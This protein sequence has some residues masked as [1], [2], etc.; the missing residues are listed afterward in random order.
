MS[1][2]L[3][4]LGAFVALAFQSMPVQGQAGA[5]GASLAE[6]ASLA[7]LESLL[8]A[9]HP[10]LEASRARARAEGFKARERESRPP[11][12]LVYQQWAVPLQRP[13]DLTQANMLMLGARLPVPSR[14][15]RKA[16]AH[17]A[18]LGAEAAAEEE[19]VTQN[20]L[21]WE[22]RQSFAEY[23]RT[24]HELALHHEHEGLVSG[25]VELTKVAYAANQV[26]AG[27][28]HEARVMLSRLHSEITML[29]AEHARARLRLN[30]LTGR[31]PDA[32]LGAPQAAE[33]RA[34]SPG[35]S[36]V[37][38]ELS[39]AEKQVKSQSAELEARKLAATRPSFMVGVDYMMMPSDRQYYGYGA[40]VS[41]TLP[42]FSDSARASAERTKH[43]LAATRAELATLSLELRMAAEEAR[44]EL[45]AA[46][47]TRAQI[48]SDWLAHAR[49]A[50]EV[51]RE[52]WALGRSQAR[53]VLQRLDALLEA[54]L[55]LVRAERDVAL[56]AADLSFALGVDAAP[57]STP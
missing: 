3:V 10:A 18:R 19:H 31:E 47:R 45:E 9:R 15:V 14:A 12:E 22:L 7:E 6:Q 42:W 52:A 46:H 55:A 40:M 23:A 5:H 11:P 29:E 53:D 38:P 2:F 54:E 50:Y 8:L 32:P 35:G 13:Y 48:A 39:R 37:R 36:S 27:T 30:L 20:R 28:M 34:V 43:E 16:D 1:R 17:A 44:V 41:M 21:L 57:R 51:E 24:H 56:R 49:E 26:S 4:C 33:A 25:V